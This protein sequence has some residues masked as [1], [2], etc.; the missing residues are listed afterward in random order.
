MTEQTAPFGSPE[1]NRQMQE[2]VERTGRV[3]GEALGQMQ[4]TF[5]AQGAM[6]WSYRGDID[7]TKT[8]LTAMTPD[9]LREVSAAASLLATLADE[10]LTSRG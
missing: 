3:L 5:A 1:W 9:Q 8:A 7:A 4:R 10:E 2:G 6:G